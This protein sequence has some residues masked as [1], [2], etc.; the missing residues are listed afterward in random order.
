M[1]ATRVEVG[2]KQISRNFRRILAP[3]ADDVIEACIAELQD[4]RRRYD[5]YT[6]RTDNRALGPTAWGYSIYPWMP[7][8]FKRSIAIPGLAVWADLCGAVR[9]CEEGAM[10]VEEVIHLRIWDESDHT[11][12]A[13]WDS[14]VICEKLTD[15]NRHQQGRVM[16]RCHFDLANTG[17][18]GPKYHL[19]I[20]GTALQEELCWL[21]AKMN[22]PR[23]VYPPMDLMLLC[24]LVA[25]NLYREEYDR[26]REDPTWKGVLR[27]S[28]EHLL[29]EY[30]RSCVGAVESGE[31]LLDILWNT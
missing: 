31:S 28:Q 14:P 30:Y 10:P 13:E 23:L 5:E 2:L 22:L 15:P 4:S 8:R 3:G 17:Q 24:Q 19:Q 21:P 20:G 18:D 11:Y 12:R 6:R 25:A 29:T 9:W 1:N 16:L 26:F 7:L 27:D